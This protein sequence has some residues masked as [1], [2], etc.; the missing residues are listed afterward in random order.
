M[1]ARF[2]TL[3]ERGSPEAIVPSDSASNSVETLALR[4]ENNQT[5]AGRFI[6]PGEISTSW[7]YPARLEPERRLRTK[8]WSQRRASSSSSQS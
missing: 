8:A 1:Q 3:A 6:N 2:P 4:N 7:P 5:A